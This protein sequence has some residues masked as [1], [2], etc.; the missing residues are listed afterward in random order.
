MEARLHVWHCV[1][2]RFWL[3]FLP[4]LTLGCVAPAEEG[5]VEK[6]HFVGVWSLSSDAGHIADVGHVIDEGYLLLYDVETAWDPADAYPNPVLG[7]LIDGHVES[8]AD[9]CATGAC[10]LVEDGEIA[11]HERSRMRVD[12]WQT[13]AVVDGTPMSRPSVIPVEE[14]ID[15]IASGEYDALGTLRAFEVPAPSG[16]DTYRL[17]RLE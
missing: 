4:L 14:R 6:R 2:V 5:L 9:G 3:T 16:D 8:E 1:D 10:T 13:I 7:W 11:W 17:E 12:W 15:P